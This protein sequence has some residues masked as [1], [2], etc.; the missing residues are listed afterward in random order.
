M[1]PAGRGAGLGSRCSD[2]SNRSADLG[3]TIV[4]LDA[5]DA[6]AEP[7]ALYPSAGYVEIPRYNDNPYVRYWFEKRL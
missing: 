1:I 6:L 7:V 3:H 4:R 2:I 5:N